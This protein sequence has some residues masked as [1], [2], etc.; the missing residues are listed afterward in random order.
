MPACPANHKANHK[1]ACS[2]TKTTNGGYIH[3]DGRRCGWTRVPGS[4][5]D[6]SSPM[7][8]GSTKDG[9]LENISTAEMQARCLADARCQGYWSRHHKHKTAGRSVRYFRPVAAWAEGARFTIGAWRGLR[10]ECTGDR[11]SSRASAAAYFPPPPWPALI[12]SSSL[13]RF[14]RAAAVADALGFRSTYLAA[15]FPPPSESAAWD[16]VTGGCPRDGYNGVRASHRNAWSLIDTVSA[17]T[18]PYLA[19]YRP[20]TGSA[21][22]VCAA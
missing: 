20:L 13:E 6:A 8:L 15:A 12:L 17:R 5:Q 2:L 4:V 19:C 16:Q 3:N 18:P 14:A 11:A 9:A 10:K 1:P 22:C 21:C 7:C